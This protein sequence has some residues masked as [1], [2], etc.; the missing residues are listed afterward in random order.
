VAA[1]IRRRVPDAA[2][3]LTG[4]VAASVSALRDLD[5]AK[6]PG[7]ERASGGKSVGRR[8]PLLRHRSEPG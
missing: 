4:E 5:L 6:P 1:I 2:A 7:G 8:G 3:A